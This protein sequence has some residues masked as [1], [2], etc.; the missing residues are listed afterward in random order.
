VQIAYPRRSI[1]LSSRQIYSAIRS[2]LSV[3]EALV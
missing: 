3:Q 1:W 2:D